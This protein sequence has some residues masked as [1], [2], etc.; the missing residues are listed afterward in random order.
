MT[1]PEPG[2]LREDLDLFAVDALPPGEHARFAA[3]LARLPAAQRAEFEAQIAEMQAVMAEYAAR[4]SDRAPEELRQ[5]VLADHAA[6]HP[7][8]REAGDAPPVA[9]IDRT[10]RRRGRAAIAVAAAAVVVGVAMGA[11]VLIGR[12]SAPR[13][14]ADAV[15][16]AAGAVF[17]APDA[18]LASS[19]LADGR[20]I[21]TVV[22]SQERDQAVVTLGG[23]ANPVP[24]DRVLQLWKLDG[25]ST[26]V[27]AG[28]FSAPGGAPVVVDD[29]AAVAA[30]AVTLEPS[31]GS[32]APTTPILTELAL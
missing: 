22:S 24:A 30:L 3:E 28:L 7:S 32:A 8:D 19:A 21:L 12:A 18:Q 26:P 25:G 23:V 5:R 4:Y 1:T 11:G 17:T 27:S 29:L 16:E 13:P 31:G 20:G 10:R 14:P 6:A 9:R 2:R 15:V